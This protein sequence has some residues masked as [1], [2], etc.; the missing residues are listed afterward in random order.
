[1]F[2]VKRFI[3]GTLLLKMK[4]VL[5][6]RQV[7]LSLFYCNPDPCF[8]SV[9]SFAAEHDLPLVHRGTCRSWGSS[10]CYGKISGSEALFF[11]LPIEMLIYLSC[12]MSIQIVLILISVKMGGRRRLGK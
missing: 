9:V 4:T 6:S 12:L 2:L 10:H 3:I 5:I 7:T 1:M 8:D 11:N